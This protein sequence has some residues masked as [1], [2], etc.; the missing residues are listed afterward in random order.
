M[1][2][3][4][5]T[6]E[7]LIENLN[8]VRNLNRS[9]DQIIEGT[10]LERTC[11]CSSQ[12]D[13]T[14]S[15]YKSYQNLKKSVIPS[16][17]E[18]NP[19]HEESLRELLNSTK[20]ILFNK[21][22]SESQDL[23]SEATSMKSK[24]SE[25]E[26]I[27]RQIGFQT[28]NPH[29]DFRAGGVFSLNVMNYY[30]KNHESKYKEMINEKYFT[31]ALVSIKLSH[32]IRMY[33]YLLPDNEIT[34]NKKMGKFVFASRKELKLFCYTLFENRNLLFDIISALLDF[35]HQKFKIEKKDLSEA[36]NYLLIE[37]IINM[38]VQILKNT[39]NDLELTDN[40]TLKLKFRCNSS[41]SE[42]LNLIPI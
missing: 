16:F 7:K 3:Q 18:N 38:A 32:F 36:E 17:D 28:G 42:K 9:P 22:I 20:K 26:Q 12:N 41:L 39:L 30:V 34:V 31:F 8:E 4:E 14:I 37:P 25:D 21:D 13:L 27:W 15:E 35:V 33:L 2:N 11:C 29:S 24:N 10:C 1:K 40:I 6:E 19:I 23:I 5:G